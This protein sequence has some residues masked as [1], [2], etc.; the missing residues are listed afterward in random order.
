MSK[1]QYIGIHG[2]A[3]SGKDTLAGML[4]DIIYEDTGYISAKVALATPL[5]KA[6]CELFNLSQDQVTDRK[7]KESMTQFGVSPR[8]LMQRMGT[9]LRKEFGSDLFLNLTNDAIV[10][11]QQVADVI[12]IPDIRYNNEAEWLLRKPNSLLIL[13]QRDNN[14]L[15]TMHSNHS[16]EAGLDLSALDHTSIWLMPNN[17]GLPELESQ[18]HELVAAFYE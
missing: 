12:I 10:I 3:G 4:A 2:E 18:A 6:V 11:A 9:I 13:L 8:E 5:K 14:P 15:K 7:L 17:K 16:S 1:L